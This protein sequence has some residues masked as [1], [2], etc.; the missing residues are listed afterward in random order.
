MEPVSE[1]CI[2]IDISNEVNKTLMLEIDSLKRENSQQQEL[3]E[4]YKRE[5]S[6]QKKLIQQLQTQLKYEII[7]NGMIEHNHRIIYPKDR[8]IYERYNL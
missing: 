5:N 2:G 8:D 6:K 7:K 3:I 1:I 4:N